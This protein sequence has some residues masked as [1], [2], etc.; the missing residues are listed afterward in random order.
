M[1]TLGVTGGSDES[2]AE[3]DPQSDRKTLGAGWEQTR[4]E[5][6]STCWGAAR[7]EM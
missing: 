1:R 6:G 4:A 2:E 7:I 3:L 5:G